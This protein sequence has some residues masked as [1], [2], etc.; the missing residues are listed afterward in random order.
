MNSFRFFFSFHLSLPL[1]LPPFQYYLFVMNTVYHFMV[2]FTLP[3]TLTKDFFEL[4][5]SQK[6]ILERLF[7]QG[8]LCSFA[9]AWETSKMWAIFAANSEY[10]VMQLLA[11]LPLSD[12]TKVH[13]S[14]LSS[15]NTMDAFL[16]QFSMN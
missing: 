10:E 9:S 5:P 11:T 2:D 8:K 4:L 1:Y 14:M 13:I 3:E 12:F 16:P 6:V 7:D 15:Y